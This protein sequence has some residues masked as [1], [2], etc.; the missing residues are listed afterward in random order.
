MTCDV[1]QR[2]RL[3]LVTG[4]SSGIGRSL[5]CLLA[6][7]GYDVALLA[8]R[9]DRLHA[10][11]GEL[12][13]R[14]G[15]AALPVTADLADP[16]TPG[17]VVDDLRGDGKTVS[18]LVNCA[19]YSHI[20]RYGEVG[21]SEHERR[22]R[23][24]ALAPLELT[25]LLLPGMIEQQWGRILNI[26]SIT[27]CFTAY[28]QDVL[29]CATKSLV[30][31]F[32]EGLAAEYADDGILCTISIPGFTDT[33]VYDSS[34]FGDYVRSRKLFQFAMMS[35]D[36][37]ARQAYEAVMSG[38]RRVVHGPHHKAMAAVLEHFPLPLRRAIAV[39]ISG[40]I[41]ADVVPAKRG[42]LQ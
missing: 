35:P 2:G 41:K 39:K 25:H 29:Y 10:L 30:E 26:G 28:P 19:G 13:S 34:G 17:R 33:E 16:Q 9:T 24:V 23:V 12:E 3:A 6:S 32:T 8:R 4:A 22:V 1:S 14:Y 38:Q 37:V 40:D 20:G 18:F 27:G 42:D 7:K 5:G 21:W 11:A 36:T 31:H 15:V